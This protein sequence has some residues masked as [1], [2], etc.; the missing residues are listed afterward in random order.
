M[1]LLKQLVVVFAALGVLVAVL[2][3]FSMDVIKLDWVVFMEIQDSYGSQEKPLPVPA[4]SIPVEGPAYLGA[5]PVN[6]IPADADSIARGAQLYSIHCQM[7]HGE[8]GQGNGTVSAFLIK[9]KPA[10]L[11]S[12][13]VQ[14]KSD[15]SFFLSI[16]NGISNPE[17]SLFPEVNFS[18]QMPPLKENLTVRERWDVVNFLR[19]LNAGQ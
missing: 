13:V 15:G 6:P 10:D 4:L 3:A 5:D 2:M 19:T 9:K 7:C 8:N 16:T 11:T 18:G 17:N 14:E 1:R 12:A